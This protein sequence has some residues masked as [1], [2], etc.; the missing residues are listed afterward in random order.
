MT[1]STLPAGCLFMLAGLTVRAQEAPAPG[2][3]KGVQTLPDAAEQALENSY[4]ADRASA[5]RMVLARYVEELA[6]LEQTLAAAGDASGAA[7]VRLEHDRVLPALGLPAVAAEDADEFAA[8]EEPAA[9]PEPAAPAVLPRDLDAIL[10]SLAPAASNKTATSPL[11]TA[12]AGSP[13]AGPS[14]KGSKRTLRMSTAA[15]NGPLDPVHPW[16]YWSS[17]RTAS[18]TLSGLP[19]GTY[20][21]VLRYACDDKAGGGKVSIRLGDTT[22]EVEVTPTGNWKR[23]GA[24]AAGSFVIKDSRADLVI[25]S[26]ALYP[27]VSY[28]MDLMAVTISPAAPAAKP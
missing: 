28:L 6:A 1:L 16:Q 3:S 20:Q 4:A 25:Q 22:R 5:L 19:A 18:W 15:L 12:A 9:V 8:F 10:Q 13:D 26:A 21:V 27:G 7:R 17:G 23:R 2:G 24:L 14:G 11:S